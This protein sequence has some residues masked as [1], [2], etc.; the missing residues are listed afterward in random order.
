MVA[1]GD[2][3]QPSTSLGIV[4]NAISSRL[5]SMARS[6]ERPEECTNVSVSNVLPICRFK[7]LYRASF[8]CLGTRV[9][10]H[11]LLAF[12]VRPSI[13][14]A[15]YVG[16]LVYLCQPPAEAVATSEAPVLTRKRL[17]HMQG[18]RTDNSGTTTTTLRL[19]RAMVA[20]CILTEGE[21]CIDRIVA[22]EVVC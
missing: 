17:V 2:V 12:N 3:G 1:G 14:Y 18:R 6:A 10:A 13:K 8:D 9:H 19:R 20:V 5:S 15:Y 22:G 7:Q 21:D 11:I 16:D 4:S